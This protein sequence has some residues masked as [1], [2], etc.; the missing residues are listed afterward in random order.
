MLCTQPSVPLHCGP[1]MQ[2]AWLS[3]PQ[4]VQ[5]LAPQLNPESQVWFAQQSWLSAPQSW[6]MFALHTKPGPQVCPAQHG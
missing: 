6:H 4:A 1:V 5:W 3:P 2:Q